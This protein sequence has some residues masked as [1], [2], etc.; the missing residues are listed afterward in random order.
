MFL[1]TMH[2]VVWCLDGTINHKT[3]SQTSQADADVFHPLRDVRSPATNKLHDL[4]QRVMVLNGESLYGAQR[5]ETESVRRHNLGFINTATTNSQT[6]S[7]TGQRLLDHGQ[8]TTPSHAQEV[9][10]PDCQWTSKK[11]SSCVTRNPRAST[12]DATWH[13]DIRQYVILI[14]TIR[15]ATDYIPRAKYKLLDICRPSAHVWFETRGHASTNIDF[16]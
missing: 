16:K 6:I 9:V 5:L 12:G 3:K 4:L 1:N 14:N 10:G 13:F 8:L 11:I 15:L 2:G 7:A